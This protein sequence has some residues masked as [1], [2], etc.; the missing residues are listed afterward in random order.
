MAQE[1]IHMPQ[2]GGGLLRYSDEVTTGY[3]MTPITVMVIILVVIV[4]ELLLH[5]G[6]F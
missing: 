4:V 3:T 6:I 2:S 1:K 5:A